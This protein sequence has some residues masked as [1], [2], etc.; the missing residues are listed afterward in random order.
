MV[1]DSPEGAQFSE[2]GPHGHES[3]RITLTHPK[4][5]VDGSPSAVFPIEIRCSPECSRHITSEAFNA[6]VMRMFAHW[7][8]QSM[9]IDGP[10]RI[11]QADLEIE[12]AVDIENLVCTLVS[13]IEA[14]FQ[15]EVTVQA[16]DTQPL[17][18][19]ILRSGK[20]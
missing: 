6:L 14:E 3:L 4:R 10:N 20:A 8:G 16:V 15:I 11:I 7:P 13:M 5:V 12:R 18:A 19:N 9:C 17:I 2:G 1:L